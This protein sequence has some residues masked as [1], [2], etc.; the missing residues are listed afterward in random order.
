[1]KENGFYKDQVDEIRRKF[2]SIDELKSK[3]DIA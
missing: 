1:L 3:M 2:G